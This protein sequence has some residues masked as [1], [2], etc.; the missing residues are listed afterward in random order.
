MRWNPSGMSYLIVGL[1]SIWL[2]LWMDKTSY[3]NYERLLHSNGK[4]RIL[5][6]V[7]MVTFKNRRVILWRSYPPPDRRGSLDFNKTYPLPSACLP[8]FFLANMPACFIECQVDCQN[9]CQIECQIEGQKICQIEC[10]QDCQNNSQVEITRGKAFFVWQ[11]CN[12]VI[13][14]WSSMLFMGYKGGLRGNLW[15]CMLCVGIVKCTWSV[16]PIMKYTPNRN[17]SVVLFFSCRW[18]IVLK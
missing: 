1:I 9:I 11:Y 5:S 4:S 2:Q 3:P 17:P 16:S 14:I 15:I 12:S 13:Y 6:T 18:T 7:S 10:Q 8:P